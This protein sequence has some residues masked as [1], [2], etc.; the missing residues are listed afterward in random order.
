[1][2]LSKYGFSFDNA[3]Y[4]HNMIFGAKV[5]NKVKILGNLRWPTLSFDCFY[6]WL[7]FNLVFGA[8]REGRYS[9]QVIVFFHIVPSTSAV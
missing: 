5:I 1:M 6:P 2:V 7:I 3:K 4:M 9:D 8:N